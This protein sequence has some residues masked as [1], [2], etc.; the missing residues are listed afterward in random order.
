MQR[1]NQVVAEIND[2][3]FDHELF[4]PTHNVEDGDDGDIDA[5][6]GLQNDTLHDDDDDDRIIGLHAQ[7]TTTTYIRHDSNPASLS[8]CLHKPYVT[9]KYIV[10]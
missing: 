6:H 3:E 7:G 10:K 9:N 8:T 2:H 4:E 5:A 1:H